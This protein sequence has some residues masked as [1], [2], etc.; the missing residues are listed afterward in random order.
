MRGPAP[1][2]CFDLFSGRDRPDKLLLAAEP[3]VLGSERGRETG[4]R[5]N[6]DAKMTDK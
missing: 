6:W 3:N 1:L 2:C 4:E 5:Y